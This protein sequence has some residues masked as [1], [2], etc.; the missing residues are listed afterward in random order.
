M[1]I[2]FS[3]KQLFSL[4]VALSALLVALSVPGLAQATRPSPSTPGDAAASSARLKKLSPAD[5]ARIF[6]TPQTWQEKYDTR[7]KTAPPEIKQRIL[8]ERA[9]I[10]ARKKRYAVGYTSRSGPAEKRVTG[11]V[12]L[13]PALKTPPA[14]TPIAAVQPSC[15]EESALP[16]QPAADMTDYA[17][18]TPVRDQGGCGDCW[19]FATTAA[20]PSRVI[21]LSGLIHRTNEGQ[22]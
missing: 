6:G 15:L 10:Q 11:L 14:H 7:F 17:I 5:K 1:K 8:K 13:A 20:H 2:G 3:A 21:L 19:A 16:N 9:D 12:G 18:V 4:A 22:K